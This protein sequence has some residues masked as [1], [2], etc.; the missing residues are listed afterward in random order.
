MAGA[1]ADAQLYDQALADLRSSTAANPSSTRVAS[2]YLL[3]G[4]IL[5][6]QRRLED[7]MANYIELRTNFRSAPEA[8]EATFRLADLTLRS[9]HTDRDRAAMTLFTEVV[10]LQPSMPL[11]AQALRRRAEI[12]ERL[13]LR[14]T[15]PRLG[16]AVPAALISY[17]LIAE[18][19]PNAEGADA[20]LAR[21]AEMYEDLKQYGPAAEALE[22]LAIYFPTN[23]YDAAWR[24]GE[25]YEKRLKNMD[26]ARTVYA[27]VPEQSPH[28]KDAQKKR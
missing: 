21:L 13:K 9:K 24:A 1:K 22:R 20:C 14:F 15:D 4:S 17:R 8:A 10:E 26:R 23:G 3:I 12:E 11:A 6:R 5:E 16:T 28:Y 7:A 2:A 19:Y 27:R 25:L 18:R